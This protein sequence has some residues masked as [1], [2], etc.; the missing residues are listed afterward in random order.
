MFVVLREWEFDW[1]KSVP[2]PGGV[3]VLVVLVGVAVIVACVVM[4]FNFHDSP[5]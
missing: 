4:R 5:S 2:V 3:A 1:E